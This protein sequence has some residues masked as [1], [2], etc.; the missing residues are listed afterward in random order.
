MPE[1]FFLANDIRYVRNV[2][3]DSPVPDLYLRL[4]YKFTETCLMVIFLADIP[5]IICCHFVVNVPRNEIYRVL[6]CDDFT[7]TFLISER[8]ITSL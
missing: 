5:D 8:D 2:F 4:H 6:E 1:D 7:I 3:K